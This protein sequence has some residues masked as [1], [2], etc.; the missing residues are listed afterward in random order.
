MANRDRTIQLLIDRGAK[1]DYQGV[2]GR[3]ALMF[4]N[5]YRPALKVLIK[6]GANLDLRNDQGNT[7]LMLAT[8]AKHT[9]AVELLKAAG[10]SLIGLTD[11]S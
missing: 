4:N 1:I 8:E 3:T 11:K 6:A 2:N 5:N 10:A 9:K 7:A